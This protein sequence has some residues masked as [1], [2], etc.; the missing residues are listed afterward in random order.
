MDAL[1]RFAARLIVLVLGV[2]CTYAA[3]AQE[4]TMTDSSNTAVQQ[5][6]SQYM[7]VI[8]GM[9]EP[10]SIP[11]GIKMHRFFRSVA[12]PATAKAVHATLVQECGLS[13]SD[14]GILAAFT[15]GDGDVQAALDAE[16]KKRT[17]VVCEHLA[18]S[19]LTPADLINAGAQMN[20]ADDKY[21]AQL[22]AHYTGPVESLSS[23]GQAIVRNY[24]DTTVAR[25]MSYGR[26]DFAGLFA[27]FPEMGQQLARNCAS[28]SSLPTEPLLQPS[29]TPDN[30]FVPA[31]RK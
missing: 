6:A 12:S 31:G 8:K 14:W 26:T 10:A 5:R 4:R 9:E 2:A 22:T 1:V 7:R 19:S 20:Q 24:V 29:L 3:L 11:Y 15:A 23:S 27:E 30:G 21:E 25:T 13:E 16:A 18:L 28:Q 17:A